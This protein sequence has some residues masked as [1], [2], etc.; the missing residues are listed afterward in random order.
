MCANFFF[1]YR[2]LKMKL[3]FWVTAYMYINKFNII[4][5]RYLLCMNTSWVNDLW[6]NIFVLSI[7]SINIKVVFGGA[8]SCT[9]MSNI[10]FVYDV[11]R[12]QLFSHIGLDCPIVFF[13]AMIS[14]LRSQELNNGLNLSIIFPAFLL[15][16]HRLNRIICMQQAHLYTIWET[17]VNMDVVI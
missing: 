12:L 4:Y 6:I 11:M 9:T 15:R 16:E 5:S 3:I 10:D 14:N 17:F 1:H 7:G 2:N 13:F 8:G